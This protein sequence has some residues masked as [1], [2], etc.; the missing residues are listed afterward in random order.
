MTVGKFFGALFYAALIAVVAVP[1]RAD[2]PAST[3]PDTARAG[4][5]R[6][7]ALRKLDLTK[8]NEAPSQIL[9]SRRSSP[10]PTEQGVCIVEGYTAP[11]VGF[12]LYLP[13][14]SWNEKFI[15]IGSGGHSGYMSD[16][17]CAAAIAKGYACLVTDMGHKGTGLD[18]QWARNNMQARMDWGYRA[19]HV[20]TVSAKVIIGEY[21]GRGP[22]KSY[23]SGCSTGGRQALQEAQKF[24]WDYDGIIAGAPPIRLSDLYVAFAW[25]ALANRDSSGLMLLKRPDLAVLNNASLAECDLDDGIKD[26]LVARPWQCAFRP[27][28]LACRPGQKIGC[29]TKAQVSAA[30]KIYTGPVDSTGRPIF[31]AGALPGS[32]RLWARYYLDDDDNELPYMFPLTRN[33]LRDL[34]SD[35][36]RADDWNI[37]Q[38]D[39][40]HDYKQLDTMQ[41]LY[42]SSN[43]DLSRFAEAGGKMIIYIGLG[44]VSIPNSIID[45]YEKVQRLAGGAQNAERFARLFLLPGVDHCSGGPGADQVD[46]L[47]YLEKW[48]EEGAPPDMLAATHFET[49]LEAGQTVRRTIFSRPVYPYPAFPKY[50]GSGDPH[51]LESFERALPGNS[52]RERH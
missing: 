14:Q 27:S 38:F 32:E 31:G 34:F 37:E 45:Y 30:E 33:G 29:L 50:R 51:R 20:V 26:G 39:F 11:Q 49:V 8:I 48:V 43:P 15:Q 4:I 3:R 46:Y 40:A 10:S 17:A 1:A 44:D 41:A 47:G 16:D 19:T 23:F 36:P 12:R 25:S 22:K 7:E 2:A 5:S 35:P 28:K 24:P 42:D 6:C 18:S 13:E 9:D 21:Y 52:E